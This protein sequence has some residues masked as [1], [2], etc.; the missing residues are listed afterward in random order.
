MIWYCKGDENTIIISGNNIKV[1]TKNLDSSTEDSFGI[2]SVDNKKIMSDDGVL[3][4]NTNNL[5][6]ASDIKGILSIDNKT[7]VLNKNGQ[8]TVNKY[9]DIMNNL[10]SLI[11]TINDE[12]KK[13]NDIEYHILSQIK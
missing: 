5:N 2:I 12:N 6:K 3:Y 9:S 11:N 13:I 8:I 1:I 4:I 10:E 7:I